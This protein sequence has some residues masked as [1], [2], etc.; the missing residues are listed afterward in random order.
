MGNTGKTHPD[1]GKGGT[2]I[3]PPSSQE[4]ECKKMSKKIFF[5]TGVL[6]VGAML[7]V[8]TFCWA[9][10]ES[11]LTNI[12]NKLSTVILPVLSICGLVIAGISFAMGNPNARQHI[13]YAV[14]G[15]IF[16]FG[17][18]AIVNFIKSIVK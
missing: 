3:S 18:E 14:L 10:L 12:Q 11:S 5:L 6:I 9:S 4:G 1:S 16:G 2:L 8:P 7:L 17:A 15:C 13:I